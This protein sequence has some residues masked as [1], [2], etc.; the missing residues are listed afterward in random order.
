MKLHLLGPLGLSFLLCG[1][2]QASTNPATT[3]E[4]DQL[5]SPPSNPEAISPRLDRASTLGGDFLLLWNDDLL[6]DLG[7]DRIGARRGGVNQDR[8]ARRFA[9]SADSGFEVDAVDLNVR[10]LAGGSGRLLAAETFVAAGRRIVW[11]NPELRVRPGAEP[12]ID[13]ADGKGEVLFY[14][15]KIMYEF[16]DQGRTFRIRSAD[17]V[18]SALLAEKL[19]RPRIAGLAVGEIK[20]LAPVANWI[21]AKAV[22]AAGA[23][24]WP[25]DPVTDQAGAPPGATWQADVFMK[26][27]TGAV[28]RCGTCDANN[29]NCSAV[30]CDGPAGAALGKVVFAPSST[31]TNNRNR[32]SALPTVNDPLGTSSALYGADVPWYEKFTSSPVNNANFDYPH[33]NFDQHPNLIWNLYRRDADGS[34]TQVGRS[35]MKHAFLTT[36]SPPSAPGGT[37]GTEN[38]N[39]VLGIAC[40][41]TYG[42]GNN[43]ASGDLGPKSELI[44]GFGIW[45]RCGSVFDANCDGI[46]IEPSGSFSNRML[47][48]EADLPSATG[49]VSYLFESWYVVRDDIN[50]YNTMANRGVVPSWGGSSW[51]IQNTGDAFALGPA[52][53]RWLP[54]GTVSAT[55]VNRELDI[56]RSTSAG[57]T[58]GETLYESG[59]SKIAV[60]VTDLQNGTWRY[61]YAVMNFDYARAA[62]TGVESNHT[63]RVLRNR[64]FNSF[65]V[66]HG[67]GVSI[68]SAVYADGDVVRP[69]WILVDD[70][71]RLTWTAP[72]SAASLDW[73]VMTRFSVIA[74]VPPVGGSVMLGVT[75]PGTPT[76]YSISSLA[77]GTPG[78]LF[79]NG[80]E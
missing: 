78:V 17:I 54:A 8:Q 14:I 27:F 46:Q 56:K 62:T 5:L 37:C 16:V 20:L 47:V 22:R 7:L 53:D 34:I 26:T 36:N 23:P 38:G 18:I 75:E 1:L 3:V 59:H 39:H 72:S 71:N 64:G 28:M 58:A 69:D 41:D 44:A 63:L 24:Y 77:I 11:R 79:Q 12:R 40:Q 33:L 30:G 70:G 65:S 29:Q 15:D 31:L 55:A 45:G 43:D 10:G 61:D 49:G 60:K 51:S 52:I 32:G 35:G 13:L 57:A 66:P 80:F 9:L 74:N 73:G 76:S 50:I 21:A 2:A 68:S 48:D 6:H 42:T 67:P 25:G 4:A 19:G